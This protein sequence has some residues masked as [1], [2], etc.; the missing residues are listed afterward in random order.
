MITLLATNLI[1]RPS[2]NKNEKASTT[3]KAP[4][5]EATSLEQ[6]AEAGDVKAQVELA[7]KYA[8]EIEDY[9][10]SFFWSQK[11]ADQ[12][13]SD[14]MLLLA[15]HYCNGRGVTK[16]LDKAEEWC[17][18]SIQL[19]N[20]SAEQLLQMI[21]SVNENPSPTPPGNTT[22]K[23]ALDGDPEAQY[24]LGIKLI[25]EGKKSEGIDWLRKAADQNY[26]TAMCELGTMYY[27]G[28]GLEKDNEKAVEWWTKAAA[29]GSEIAQHN[30]E[31][32]RQ[33]KGSD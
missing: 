7:L 29:A 26:P 3:E 15:Q 6:L 16:N 12:N 5:T 25:N 17:E 1:S 32:L 14:G 30:L 4:T 33:K 10:K 23:Q 24:N 2:N 18:K 19:G 31:V 8:N 21:T 28:I 22:L 27:G 9:E 11:A 20:T 13:D